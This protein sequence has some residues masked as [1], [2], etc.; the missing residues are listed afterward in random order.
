MRFTDQFLDEIRDR[1]PIS[2]VIGKRVSF[3]RKKSNPSRGDFWAC[4]PFHGEKTPSFHCEDR[5]GRYHC[6]GCHVS[7][8]HFRFLTELDGI[9]FPEAVK[10]LADEA[11]LAMPV[12]SPRQR[13]QEAKRKSLYD[14]MELAA[15][16][17]EEQLQSGGGAKARAYLRGRN[18]SPD[19]QARFRIGYAPPS[20]NALKQFLA[21]KDIPATDIETA[22]LVVHG[23]EIAVSYDRF[24]DRVIFPIPD[25]R[26]RIIAF[27][28]RALSADVPAKYLNSPETPVFHKSN[29]L[30]NY[31]NAR[32]AARDAGTIIVTEGYMDVIALA[33]AGLQHSVAP[34]G[35]ALTERQMLL[36]W[37]LV[38]EPVLC[39]DGDTAGLNA[40]YRSIDMLLAGLEPG[41]SARFALLP[42][43]LDPDDLISREGPQAMRDVIAKALPLADMI[44]NRAL[45][46]GV[47][48]TPE[49]RAAL[50][51]DVRQTIN[52]ITNETVRRHYQQDM[53]S[54]L[55]AWFA[56]KGGSD[57]GPRTTGSFQTRGTDR[58]N[59]RSP[60]RPAASP[61]LLNSGLL[62][63]RSGG[64]SL[65]EVALIMGAVNHPA[66]LNL[67]FDEFAEMPLA[68]NQAA[69]LRS[70]IVD[71]Y[72]ENSAGTNS[73]DALKA[74]GM[75][76]RLIEAG[77]GETMERFDAQMVQNRIWQFG[78]DA[79]FE[80]SMEGWRQAYALHVRQRS[81]S[82]ELKLAQ[83]AFAED[84]SQES[85]DRIVEIQAELSRVD[86]TE[87]L[88]EGFGVSSG[89]PMRRF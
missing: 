37:R 3:D 74:N 6:F 47:F 38:A 57:T 39:F 26:G 32:D 69:A 22:G 85:L 51:A 54:R 2:Q 48:D 29:V 64:T 40:A 35:T 24:R 89:R 16:F 49:R 42:E 25:S 75:R 50:E 52:L 72:M 61:S 80:D 88:I 8:D 10:M 31:A 67:F 34:L 65:R 41:R 73:G 43:G 23:S 1:V 56:D 63:R 45:A 5:K 62:K 71:F 36:L 59:S 79:A 58:Q 53:Q 86:G 33:C 19:I 28:G 11:G 15:G 13:E 66:I 21:A 44:W 12:E 76:Q 46:N 17:F 14:V 70:A 20:R 77:H 30:Y 78:L 82:R 18:L 55:E 9:S 81:L 7:G 27:G 4:C 83:Q 84:G 60:L 87:A 68:S